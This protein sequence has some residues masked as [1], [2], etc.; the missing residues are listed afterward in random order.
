M[1]CVTPSDPST[2][3]STSQILGSLEKKGWHLENRFCLGHDSQD[4]GEKLTAICSEV[5]TPIGHDADGKIVWDIKAREPQKGASAVITYSEH[6]HEADLHTDSQYNDYP[7]D[8]FSLLTLKRAACGGG[9]SS[10]LTLSDILVELSDTPVGREVLNILNETEFPFIVP[11]V[12]KKDPE[13]EFEFVRGRVINQEAHEIRFRVDTI[14]KALAHDPGLCTAAQVR[15][16][17]FF[18]NL[19]RTTK[20]T[21]HF[22]L[23]DGDL[24]FINNK[25]TLHGRSSFTDPERHLLRVRMNKFAA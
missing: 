18:K 12:F 22:F 15:A 21:R 11:A 7:E 8:Y 5:G 1:D 2:K 17:N 6:N 20:Q 24:I 13:K 16:F 10:L 14:E 3:L 23:N 25:T 19:V 9:E 4:A